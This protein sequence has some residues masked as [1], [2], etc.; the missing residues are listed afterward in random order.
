MV[1]LESISQNDQA[2]LCTYECSQCGRVQTRVVA[3]S[4]RA[5]PI[6]DLSAHREGGAGA[7][8]DLHAELERFSLDAEDCE[9]IANLATDL[10]KRAMFAKL[11]VQLRTMARDVELIMVKS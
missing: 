9:L 2:D 4:S 11:A 7:M 1:G 10:K 3:L 6:T 8:E 5:D